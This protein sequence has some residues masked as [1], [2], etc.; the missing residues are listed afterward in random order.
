MSE[1]VNEATE[2]VTSKLTAI[3]DIMAPVKMIQVRSNYAPWLS[4]STK[5]KIKESDK[6]KKKATETKL[7][8]DWDEYRKIRNSI[9][10]IL[11]SENVIGR[12]IKYLSLVQTQVQYGKISSTG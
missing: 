9:N 11:K 2:M 12:K 8:E 10:N 6:A 1:N 7:S 4:E 5:N 3:L